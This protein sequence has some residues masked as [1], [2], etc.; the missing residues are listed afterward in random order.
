MTDRKTIQRDGRRYVLVPEAAYERMIEDLDELDDI[1]AYD[2]AKAAPQEFVP[3]AI[4]DRL[5]AGE[6]P[7]RVWREHRGFTQQ[8]LADATG[9]S[10]PFLSQLEHRERE[11][12]VATLRK[13]AAALGVDLDDLV[14]R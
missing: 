13:L 9:I 5:I 12:S 8:V 14:K 4:V 10:K 2:R 3:A 6:N 1:R 11:A 7:L